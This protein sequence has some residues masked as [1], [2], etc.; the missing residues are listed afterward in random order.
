LTHIYELTYEN[1]VENPAKHH[2]QI[3]DF[4]GTRPTSD[5]M[6]SLSSVHNQK[7]LNRWSNLL[8]NSPWKTYYLYIA[9]KYEPKFAK[10]NYFLTKGLDANFKHFGGGTKRMTARVGVLYCL[11]TDVTWFFR[12]LHRRKMELMTKPVRSIL[13]RALKD[14]MKRALQRRHL[15]WAARLLAP[16]WF[17]Q[18]RKKAR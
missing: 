12:R 8:T 3:A 7:Y 17:N 16:V 9:S 13:P 2:R 1:Y 14:R 6:E 11:G 18:I 10:Y 15:H 4:I 5:Q